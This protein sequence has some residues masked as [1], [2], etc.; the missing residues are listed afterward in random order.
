MFKEEHLKKFELDILHFV[1]TG[2][3]CDI[4]FGI[5]KK[6]LISIGLTP[7]GWLNDR[8]IETSGLWRFGNIEFYF[9]E[10]NKLISIF[11][12]YVADKLSGGRKI[13]ITNYWLLKR[14][15]ITLQRT[16][17]ELLCLKLDFN[18][19]INNSGYIELRLTNGVYFL[20]DFVTDLSDNHNVW[21]MTAIGKDSE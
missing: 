20:F 4:D 16:I 8:T 3:F 19:K 17:K 21:T 15:K 7:E 13:E 10:T 6:E 12:D 9:D 2:S 18:K 11:T 1:L 5:T 14:R